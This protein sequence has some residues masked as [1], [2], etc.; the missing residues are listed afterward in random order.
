[1][2]HNSDIVTV[3]LSVVLPILSWTAD[4]LLTIISP[5]QQ[6]SLYLTDLV[7]SHIVVISQLLHWEPSCL[8]LPQQS[9]AAT[10][11]ITF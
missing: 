1:M 10:P 11:K 6:H 9:D 5:A 8:F 4:P 3:L 2:L 7:R